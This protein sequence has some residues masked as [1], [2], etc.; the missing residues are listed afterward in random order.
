M[1]YVGARYHYKQ[2]WNFLG[3]LQ[4]WERRGDCEVVAVGSKWS[5]E[6]QLRLAAMPNLPCVRNLGPLPDEDLCKLYNEAAA[7]VYPSLYEGFGIPL[8]EA[9]ACR[10]PVV[11]SDI[12][13][14]REVAADAAYYFTPGDVESLRTALSMALDAGRQSTR[15]GVGVRRA[16]T[17]NWNATAQRYAAIYR[18]I[19]T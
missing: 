1:L 6:E 4:N 9:M 15:V 13:S 2:F 12:P 10:C 3:A 11:A 16:A 17:F 5:R 8:L 18:S 14:T 7:F 19:A